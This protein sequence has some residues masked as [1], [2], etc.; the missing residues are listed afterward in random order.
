[1]NKIP[2][3]TRDLTQEEIEG[4]QFLRLQRRQLHAANR[5]IQ[6]HRNPATDRIRAVARRE[7]RIANLRAAIAGIMIRQ[8]QH[9]M[10]PMQTKGP[11]ETIPKHPAKAARYMDE[12]ATIC[13]RHVFPYLNKHGIST[14]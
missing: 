3:T 9:G 12:Y 11:A 10:I 2:N 4:I 8:T 6:K 1:M 7:A 13:V 5:V 14:T